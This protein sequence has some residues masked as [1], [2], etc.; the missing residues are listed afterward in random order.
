M[1][2]QRV[3]MVRRNV[4]ELLQACDALRHGGVLLRTRIS[5]ELML[6]RLSQRLAAHEFAQL[7]YVRL[8]GRG[9]SGHLAM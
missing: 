2:L 9:L 5:L 8:P 7:A 3:V 1:S 6:L 4:Y